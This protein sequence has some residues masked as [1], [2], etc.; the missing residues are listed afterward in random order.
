MGAPELLLGST[1][2]TKGV[3]TWSV[4][5][6]LGELINGKPIFPGSSTMNQL[7]RIM[8]VTGKPT[9]EDIK[10]T[11]SAFAETMLESV[12]HTRTR[13]LEEMFPKGTPA[14]FK[15]MSDCLKFNPNQRVSPENAAQF[16]LENYEYV[17]Q[18]HNPEEELEHPHPIRIPIDDN[19]KLTVQDYRERLYEEVVKKKKEQRRSHRAQL[20]GQS[21]GQREVADSGE[22]AVQQKF[23]IGE[24]CEYYSVSNGGWIPAVIKNFDKRTK[25]YELNYRSGVPEEKLRAPKAHH[26][27]SG[28]GGGYGG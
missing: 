14:A 22:R 23:Q 1:C 12:P 16:A 5:C 4:G 15:L 27:Q 28:S 10:G 25:M 7:E 3:D 19:T 17:R 9:A 24:S 11:K 2:Y 8:E 13:R 6:I 18:F 26:S 21:G 20:E